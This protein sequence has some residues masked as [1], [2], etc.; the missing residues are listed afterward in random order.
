MYD[1]KK[2]YLENMRDII[3][4]AKISR[5]DIVEIKKIERA[6]RLSALGISEERMKYYEGL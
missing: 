3:M 6:E 4:A 5:I 1:Y 2:S